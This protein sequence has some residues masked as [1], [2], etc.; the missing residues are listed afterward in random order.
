MDRGTERQTETET[1]TE[2]ERK[3]GG[4]GRD[5]GRKVR[6]WTSLHKLIVVKSGPAAFEADALTTRPTRR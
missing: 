2:E 3:R 6:P 1:E 4:R 5:A